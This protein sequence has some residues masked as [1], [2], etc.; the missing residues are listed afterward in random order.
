MNIETQAEAFF[1]GMETSSFD[2]LCL[3][4]MIVL[5]FIFTHIIM[6]RENKYEAI[7]PVVMVLLLFSLMFFSGNKNSSIFKENIKT[8]N[9]AGYEKF[10]PYS[11]R[12]EVN[13]IENIESCKKH[14]SS[15]VLFVNNFYHIDDKNPVYIFCKMN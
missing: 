9:Q 7:V 12:F 14:G 15:E 10:A 13:N 3:F 11:R 4:L 6:Y 2:S 8:L 1:W 5:A